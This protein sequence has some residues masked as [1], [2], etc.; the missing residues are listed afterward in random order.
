MDTFIKAD[1]N[2]YINTKFIRWIDEIGQCYYICN[3]MDGCSINT[4]SRVCKA[5]NPESYEKIKKIIN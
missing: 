1:E 3:R 5:K 2:K 4:T